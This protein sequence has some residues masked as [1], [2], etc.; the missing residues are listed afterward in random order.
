M[1]IDFPI[2]FDDP[3]MTA[4]LPVKLNISSPFWVL[5]FI[6]PLHRKKDH[7]KGHLQIFFVKI[8]QWLKI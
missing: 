7:T 3:V 6:L 1:A 4:V 8:Q 5:E 2:P